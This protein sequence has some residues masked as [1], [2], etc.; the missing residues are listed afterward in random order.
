MTM[1]LAQV[2][3][4]ADSKYEHDDFKILSSL[5][6]AEVF[7]PMEQGGCPLVKSAAPSKGWS[8]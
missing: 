6:G 4:P 5:P 2:K 7:K 1:Y 8:R 3:S